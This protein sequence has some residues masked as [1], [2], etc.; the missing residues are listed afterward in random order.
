MASYVWV[1]VQSTRTR[2][3]SRLRRV[4]VRV[5]LYEH[6]FKTQSE[7]VWGVPCTQIQADWGRSGSRT[8][9]SSSGV[10]ALTPK[11]VRV[12]GDRRSR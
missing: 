9:R 8:S 3:R 2:A 11:A 5:A 4:A 6:F 1:H 12:A 7:K 10:G